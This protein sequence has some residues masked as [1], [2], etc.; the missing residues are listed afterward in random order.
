VRRDELTGFNPLEYFNRL[1]VGAG[2]FDLL[3]GV[4]AR[5]YWRSSE[6]PDGLAGI[7]ALL[8]LRSGGDLSDHPERSWR[9]S[10]IR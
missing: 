5:G 1:P 7:D 9:S 2:D 4:C 6:Y 8:E 3:Y 10:D